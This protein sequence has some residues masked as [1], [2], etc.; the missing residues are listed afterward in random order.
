MLKE[1]P[2]HA[3]D[4]VS[5][6]GIEVLKYHLRETFPELDPSQLQKQHTEKVKSYIDWKAMHCRE[7]HYPSQIRT[8]TNEA[9]CLAP[10][11]PREMLFWVPDPVMEEDGEH[12][13]S[14]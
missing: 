13:E 12:L 10:E 8:Y 14:Y 5:E 1:E 2:V 3:I 11:M 7:R 6:D 4:P 9:C